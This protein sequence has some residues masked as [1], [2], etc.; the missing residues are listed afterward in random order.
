MLSRIQLGLCI[1]LFTVSAV[2]QEAHSDRTRQFAALPNWAGIW[3]GEV[4]HELRSEEFG[5]VMQ[6]A[7]AHPE[8]MPTVAPPGALAPQEVFVVSR[9][10][11]AR[12]P[13]Y[14][15]EWARR[16]KQRER[17]IKATPVSAV[18]PGSI[19]AC[20]WDFPELMDNP[21]DTLFQIY[22]TPEETLLLF[23]NGQARHIYTDRSHPGPDDLWPSALG[24][25]V[26]HWEADTLL[27]DTIERR[28]GPFVRIPHIL[29]PDLSEQARFSERIRMVDPDTLEDEMTIED[30]ERLTRPWT[31]TLKFH[32]VKDL[33]RLIPTNCT[34]NDRFRVIQG[35]L[36]IAPP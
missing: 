34:E 36:T 33:D 12:E 16:Y 4:A 31:V 19:K 2:A 3:E 8:N 17:K 35:H 26:G 11:L 24:N 29:S 20:D 15:A 25:S 18:R 7:L 32:R 9:T 22:V 14:N 13:P 10:Q 5:K 21:F 27:V 28:G 1:A 6:E 30:A 23:V